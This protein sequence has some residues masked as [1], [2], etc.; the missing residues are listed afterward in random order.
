MDRSRRRRRRPRRRR[1]ARRHDARPTHNT[2]PWTSTW[3]WLWMWLWSAIFGS[4]HWALSKAAPNENQIKNS[5]AALRFLLLGAL[6]YLTP[7]TKIFFVCSILEKFNLLPLLLL[8]AALLFAA[9][10]QCCPFFSVS[11]LVLNPAQVQPST[12]SIRQQNKR[13]PNDLSF[14]K[15]SPCSL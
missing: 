7:N 6:P 4:A 11:P 10:K 14:M 1:R 9:I 12:L 13:M 2:T 15:N 3:M 8:F 5:F